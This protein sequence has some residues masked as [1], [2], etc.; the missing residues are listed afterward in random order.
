MQRETNTKIKAYLSY[1][2]EENGLSKFAQSLLDWVP[3]DIKLNVDCKD[4]ELSRPIDAFIGELTSSSSVIFLLNEG[5]FKSPWCMGELYA[6]LSRRHPSFHG[7]FIACDDWLNKTDVRDN[8]YVFKNKL[9]EFWRDRADTTN[10]NK[11]SE[12]A[13]KFG[14]AIEEI[15]DVVGRLNLPDEKVIIENK[16]EDVWKQIRA[17]CERLQTD[18]VPTGS[19][20][21]DDAC[22]KQIIERLEYS[23]LLRRKLENNLELH[24]EPCSSLV[25]LIWQKNVKARLT[26]F[27]NCSKGALSDCEP[28]YKK[29]L[30]GRI[31][32]I[33][34]VLLLGFI[35]QKSRDQI[36]NSSPGMFDVEGF[37]LQE[38]GP[39]VAELYFA[40]MESTMVANFSYN[41]KMERFDVNKDR[42]YHGDKAQRAVNFSCSSIIDAELR[43]IW[44]LTFPNDNKEPNEYFNDNEMTRLSEALERNFERGKAR[45]FF[46]PA[47]K[48]EHPLL[49]PG[50]MEALKF[51]L[52]FLFIMRVGVSNCPAFVSVDFKET[53]IVDELASFVD[54]FLNRE[55]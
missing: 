42:C 50:V 29:N 7:F 37:D 41:D 13:Q 49:Q 43:V 39:E 31:L 9:T 5:F 8:F 10:D 15:V 53:S 21:F 2:R 26:L 3:D 44:N 16:A 38:D 54:L 47:N 33:L 35:N 34:A 32:E 48:V 25:K 23:N 14:D 45:Y 27:Y 36:I 18:Y 40:S 28:A 30:Q 11:T 22:R 4:A 52:P 1:R 17:Q 51:K 12:E 46:V 6:F 24:G 55:H 20:D 19:G